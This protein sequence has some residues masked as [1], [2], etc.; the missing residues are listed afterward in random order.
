MVRLNK[1]LDPSRT[2]REAAKLLSDLRRMVVGQE[3]AVGQIVN[4]YQ[5]F[6]T[7][8]TSPGRPIGNFLFLGSHG[9]W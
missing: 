5:M 3:D 6:L 8:M 4:I 7:G 1:T 2:G 9:H